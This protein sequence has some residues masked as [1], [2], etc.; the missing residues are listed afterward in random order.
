MEATERAHDQT[1][2]VLTPENQQVGV[3]FVAVR[4]PDCFYSFNDLLSWHPVTILAQHARC[5][6]R[7]CVTA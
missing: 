3:M 7:V 5:G 6:F 4:F 1:D 2:W